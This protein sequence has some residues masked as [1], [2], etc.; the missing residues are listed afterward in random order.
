MTNKIY[1]NWKEF[2]Y[3]NMTKG[4]QFGLDKSFRK[5]E[6][7]IEIYRQQVNDKETTL[8]IGYLSG[9]RL[10][11][12]H[13]FNDKTPGLNKNQ[14]EYF[15]EHDFSENESY[16]IPGLEFTE[17]NQQAI[18]DQLKQGLD[19]KE[20]IYTKQG[21]LT[22]SKLTIIYDNEKRNSFTHTYRFDNISIWARLKKLFNK[23]V[24]IYETKEINLKEIFGGLK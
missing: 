19:G 2:I 3:A 18:L 9:D 23:Q 21:K 1:K 17:T 5:G 11:Y 8:E 15:N 6:T 7:D 13:T 4:N 20:I 12:L 14:F 10:I 24:D 22:H 16:G